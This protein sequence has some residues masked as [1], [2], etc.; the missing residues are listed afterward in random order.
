MHSCAPF[1]FTL[2]IAALDDDIPVLVGVLPAG[3]FI[4]VPEG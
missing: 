4:A 2:D 1:S 3:D